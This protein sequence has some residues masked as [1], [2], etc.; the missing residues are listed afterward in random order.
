MSKLTTS[1][2]ASNQTMS[3]PKSSVVRS[4]KDYLAS[5]DYRLIIAGS[6]TVI[7][8]GVG[9]YYLWSPKPPKTKSRPKRRTSRPAGNADAG[10]NR[11]GRTREEPETEDF[12][13][14]TYEQINVLPMEKRVTASQTLK[15]RGNIA[16]GQ[17]NYQK[18]I[19]LYTKAIAF[20]QDPVFYSNRAAC[21]YN[22]NEYARVIEDCNNA[23]QMDPL[24]VKALNRRA[25]AYE[26]TS[27]YEESLHDFTAVC[28][29]GEFRNENATA[30]IDRLLKKVAS[31]KAKQIIQ[32]RVKRLP[33]TKF[34]S[35]Y[36]EAFR[37]VRPY[38]VDNE[39]EGDKFYNAA[40]NFLNEERY[41]E[42]M[43]EYGKAIDAGCSYMAEA[44]NMRGTFTYLMG[45]SQGALEDFK[46]ALEIK[47]D[48]VQIY[49]KRATIYMEQD[50][51]DLAYRE[52]DEAIKIDP[53]DPDIYYH[54]GQV[55]FLNSMFDKAVDEYQRRIEL[56]PDFVY[57]YIQLAIAQYKNGSVAEGIKTCRLG[58]QKFIQS[59]EM[60]NYYGELL[61]DQKKI[62]EAMEQ[63]DKAIELQNGNFALPFVNKAMLCFHVKNDHAQAE[64]FCRKALEIEPESD[65]AN[66]IMSEILLARGNLEEALQYLEKYQEVART[67]TELQGILEYAEAARS[68]IAFKR[69]YPQHANRAS[70]L[71]R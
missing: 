67:E 57:A 18:A 1:N 33:S 26:Q 54:R 66:T 11:G 16:F 34:I 21:Y 61:A 69:R 55:Y 15:S 12:E 9:L 68:H 65:I 6:V 10:K 30:S 19:A 4:V 47:P 39:Q 45:D 44:L 52:F 49:V 40:E 23:L 14:Y 60:H 32:N 71:A 38:V 17:N 22:T 3:E 5:K 27:R 8:V 63:F 36:M 58:L 59:A 51:A 41:E 25:M 31:I 42:A 37:K 64:E 70:S 48:Y 24:Y 20:N 53:N 62:D 13:N 46:K 35:S 28:I 7:V 50:N 29:I 43:K 2:V 56:D